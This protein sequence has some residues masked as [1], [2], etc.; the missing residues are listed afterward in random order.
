[1]DISTATISDVFAF[2]LE[3]EGHS[4]M[5]PDK[6]S[7]YGGSLF[8]WVSCSVMKGRYRGSCPACIALRKYCLDLGDTD[9]NMLRRFLRDH[10]SYSD[11]AVE[12]AVASH[13]KEGIL[14]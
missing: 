10:H 13:K 6:R 7:Q 3:A 1:M 11:E 4:G 2:L 14:P 9:E 12:K 8:P 5:D